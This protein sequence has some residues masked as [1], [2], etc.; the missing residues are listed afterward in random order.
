MRTKEELVDSI[1][2]RLI[3]LGYINIEKLGTIKTA[4]SFCI[5]EKQDI[6]QALQAPNA[7]NE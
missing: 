7:I 2:A 3:R 1:I 4:N 6:D 5:Q